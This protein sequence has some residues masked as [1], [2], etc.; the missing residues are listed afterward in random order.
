VNDLARDP[1]NEALR[2]PLNIEGH[3]LQ[4][5]QP[6]GKSDPDYTICCEAVEFLHLRLGLEH[7]IA[8]KLMFENTQ[9]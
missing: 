5:C 9:L 2:G 3:R 4:P 7:I 8:L 6:S 1:L